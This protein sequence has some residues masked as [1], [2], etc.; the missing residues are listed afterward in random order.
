[1]FKIG[2]GEPKH[3]Q[4]FKTAREEKQAAPQYLKSPSRKTTRK[5]KAEP[6]ATMNASASGVDQKQFLQPNSAEIA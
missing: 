1:M 6:A 5:N 3:S 4:T 2:D